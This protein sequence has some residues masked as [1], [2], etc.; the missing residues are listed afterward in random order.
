LAVRG[1]GASI[2]ESKLKDMK[3]FIETA[4]K[5]L[6][7]NKDRLHFVKDGQEVLPGVHAI[8][9]PGHTVKWA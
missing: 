1:G 6:L 8:Y 2:N 3:A 7:P 9:A 5:N 4:R